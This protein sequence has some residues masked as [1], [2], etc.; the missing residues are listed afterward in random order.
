MLLFE[1]ELVSREE[2][3]P[4]GYLFVWH[5]DPPANLFE[6]L[7]LNKDGE[8]PQEEV[9]EEFSP[10]NKHSHTLGPTEA[11]L[12]DGVQQ[13]RGA[14]PPPIC[15]SQG[16]LGAWSLP[17]LPALMWP[18]SP[19]T[20]LALLR[21]PALAPFLSVFTGWPSPG[22]SC[23]G[24]PQLLRQDPHTHPPPCSPHSQFSTFIKAQVTEGKGRLMPGQDPEKTIGD[25]FQNQD[26]NQDGK[27]TLEE[28]K[29]K[30]DEDQERVHEEL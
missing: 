14:C 28:L 13:E 11:T 6:D 15:A 27:I 19:A 5:E 2:G 22:V 8:V 7:D 20:A 10:Y 16:A 1:V 17:S 9:G 26:R 29:L 25:M 4:E 30:S 24:H 18:V 12:H 23:Q 3:L 21:T